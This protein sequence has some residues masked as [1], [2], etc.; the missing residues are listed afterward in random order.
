MYCITI[1]IIII[2]IIIITI[3]HIIS[4]TPCG[5]VGGPTLLHDE[6]IH[7]SSYSVS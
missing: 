6:G 1:V 5:L 4:I 3:I 7:S 2:V